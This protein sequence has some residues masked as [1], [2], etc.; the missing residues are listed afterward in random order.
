VW[1]SRLSMVAGILILSSLQARAQDT[2]SI[3]DVRCVLVGM[4]F[5]QM[6][7][8]SLH[9]AGNMLTM[10]YI[11]RLDGRVPSLDIEEL[12]VREVSQM[13]TADYGSEAKRCGASLSGKGQQITRIGKDIIEREQKML[14]K[15]IS[16]AK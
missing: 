4:K 11:G 13:T 6:T 1:N 5:V 16:P 2:E 3:S 14:N 10:Y 8:P 9:E 15:Q 12:I 7:D